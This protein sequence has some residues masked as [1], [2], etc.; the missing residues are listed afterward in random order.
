MRIKNIDKKELLVLCL[1]L[2]AFLCLGPL[3]G[4]TSSLIDLLVL[5]DLLGKLLKP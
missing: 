4:D 3:V 1:G 5:A 2:T